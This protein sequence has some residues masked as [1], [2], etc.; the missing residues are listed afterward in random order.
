MLSLV[1]YWFFVFLFL[2]VYFSY[3][4]FY[5]DFK[6]SGIMLTFYLSFQNFTSFRFKMCHNQPSRPDSSLFTTSFWKYLLKLIWAS[7][8]LGSGHL[9]LDSRVSF[10]ESHSVLGKIVMGTK[11][12]NVINANRTILVLTMQLSTN[13]DRKAQVFTEYFISLESENIREWGGRTFPGE[14]TAYGNVSSHKSMESR[15]F[16]AG[17]E[18]VCEEL[19]EMSLEEKGAGVS[20]YIRILACVL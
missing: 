15:F 13:C 10:F 12:T 9:N 8:Y 17:A 14:E 19:L 20:R 5:S 7:H 16:V 6:I 2:I 1:S 11:F 4:V 18:C 3:T